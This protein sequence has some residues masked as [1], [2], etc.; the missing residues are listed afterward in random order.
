MEAQARFERLALE[1][2]SVA[3]WAPLPPPAKQSLFYALKSIAFGG[4]DD[5]KAVLPLSARGPGGPGGRA[6]LPP[7]TARAS[8]NR[9]LSELQAS[10]FPGEQEH[11]TTESARQEELLLRQPRARRD[12]ALAERRKVEGQCDSLT[13]KL[14][15]ESKAR[16]VLEREA[17]ERRQAVDGLSATL[18]TELEGIRTQQK[19]LRRLRTQLRQKQGLQV[20]PRPASSSRSPRSPRK[21]SR[22]C[23]A[24]AETVPIERLLVTD[25]FVDDI[26]YAGAATASESL[27]PPAAASPATCS[28]APRPS[29]VASRQSPAVS[30][31]GSFGAVAEP[32]EVVPSRPTTAASSD[33]RGQSVTAVLAAQTPLRRLDPIDV[34]STLEGLLAE[35]RQIQL[36]FAGGPGAS[37]SPAVASPVAMMASTAASGAASEAASGGFRASCSG[38][39]RSIGLQAST[40]DHTASSAGKPWLEQEADEEAEIEVIRIGGRAAARLRH[41]SGAQATVDLRSG[42]ILAWRRA[43][44]LTAPEGCVALLQPSFLDS[45]TCGQAGGAS[46]GSWRLTLMDDSNNEPSVTLSCGGDGGAWPWHL[47]RTLSLDAAYL[48]ESLTIESLA[49][50]GIGNSVSSFE[51]FSDPSCSGC[52][53]SDRQVVT[54]KRGGRW[55]TSRCWLAPGRWIE[56][57]VAEAVTSVNASA[58]GSAEMRAG[59]A[60]SR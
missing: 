49:E 34:D 46:S 57:C 7:L 26:G 22:G 16:S 28:V 1:A 36:A 48:R 4:H 9:S 40:R 13:E 51:V 32:A 5:G 54:L 60:R 2:Q 30:L 59:A 53:D 15:R 27:G 8:A 19:L 58:A 55:V 17:Q 42:R 45:S 29:R 35:M 44:G 6:P 11:L 39:G 52:A 41:P 23:T 24:P 37:H 18:A 50:G 47:R 38:T 43:D 31:S 33:A 25:A 20:L 14:A 10:A 12:V 56:T 3:A 21:P